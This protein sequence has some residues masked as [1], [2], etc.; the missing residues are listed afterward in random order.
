MLISSKDADDTLPRRR[1]DVNQLRESSEAIEKEAMF[2]QPTPIYKLIYQSNW[3]ER[4]E[5]L[6]DY[7]FEEIFTFFNTYRIK[8]MQ[9]DPIFNALVRYI[10][11]NYPSFRPY[12][13]IIE[14]LILISMII[15]FLSIPFK[16]LIIPAIIYLMIIATVVHPITLAILLKIIGIGLRIVGATRDRRNEENCQDYSAATVLLIM[17]ICSYLIVSGLLNTRFV[18]IFVILL[19]VC[20][21]VIYMPVMIQKSPTGNIT[22][23]L[24]TVALLLVLFI[25]YNTSIA[26][27]SYKFFYPLAEVHLYEDR[28]LALENSIF[29]KYLTFREQNPIPEYVPE[30][31]SR[32]RFKPYQYEFDGV[33]DILKSFGLLVLLNLLPQI[34]IQATAHANT[35]TAET[36]VNANNKKEDRINQEY[37]MG[38]ALFSFP[39]YFVIMIAESYVV[40][41]YYLTPAAGLC[42]SVIITAISVPISW[43]FTAAYDSIYAKAALNLVAGEKLQSRNINFGIFPN[44]R[45]I[46]MSIENLNLFIT[47]VTLMAFIIP[48]FAYSRTNFGVILLGG[49]L[50]MSAFY[51]HT[52]SINHANQ[53][54]LVLGI[55]IITG[56]W[57]SSLIFMFYIFIKGVSF[58]PFQSDI[59]RRADGY[60]VEMAT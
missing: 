29:E 58:T 48:H 57:I 2:K 5:F 12:G 31:T 50:V 25:M 27:M 4:I 54:Y 56:S 52:T 42:L 38:T 16:V 23:M 47:I 37:K 32:I 35:R 17:A 18:I 44:T 24:G 41:M 21:L 28:I 39:W 6:K 26:V 3:E 30:V 19:T 7:D 9:K 1:I 43:Q 15:I 49:I 8:F 14:I 60:P 20:Y 55:L 13:E 33:V 36:V 10:M 40:C 34:L 53:K 51:K 45:D 46:A 22:M 11:K 59:L